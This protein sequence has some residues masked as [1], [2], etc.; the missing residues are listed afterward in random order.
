MTQTATAPRSPVVL[1]SPKGPRFNK[2]DLRT[3]SAGI[4]LGIF[5]LV[6]V[7]VTG[8]LA[9]I[10]GH[11]GVGDQTEYKAVFSN[12]SQ[13]K[14]G[15]DVRVAGVSVGEVKD[16]R[17]FG[18]DKAIVTFKVESSVP[19]TTASGAQIRYLNLVG[20]RYLAL[21]Q[22]TP[23]AMRLK[24]G[25]EIPESQTQPAINLTELFNGFQPLFQALS[26]DDVN[27]L[28]NNL[29]KVLQGEG[30]TIESLLS[31]TAS[32]TSSLADRDQLIS[33][34]ISNL[35]TTLKTVDAHRTQLADLITQLS[36]WMGDLSGDRAAIGDSIKQIGS[37]TDSLAGLLTDARP[38][39]K[40]DI[41]QLKRI[42]TILNKPAN[43]AVMD[44]TLKRLPKTLKA[45]T[46][47]GTHGSWYNYYLCDFTMKLTLPSLG[48]AIDDSPVMKQ[49]QTQLDNLAIYS[50]AT[51]CNP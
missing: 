45:Q 30:G 47:I 35:T 50:T 2:R 12:A 42:M 33:S 48:K 24:A 9:L 8:T 19:M 32:L 14:G 43:Q 16:V 10:M 17:I 38:W 5:I 31:Q 39:T 46:R 25:Q 20:D 28:S 37:L 51:R 29:I 40:A 15:D 41:V 26:P 11:I 34:V 18:A 1:P 44:E 13:L 21:T 3:I 4:K 27:K 6:S 22:G 36:N 49:L 23:G 7:I